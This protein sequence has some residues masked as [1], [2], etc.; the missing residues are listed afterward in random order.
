MGIIGWILLGGLSGWLAAYLMEERQGCLVN[1]LVGIVGAIL[2]GV[3]FSAIG[4]SGI[5][6][7]NIWSFAVAVVGSVVFLFILRMLREKKKGSSR[8]RRKR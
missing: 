7:F 2:G 4:G 1:V 6:G 5:T 3:L 8:E